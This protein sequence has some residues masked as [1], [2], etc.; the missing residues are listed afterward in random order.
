MSH[1]AHPRLISLNFFQGD[2]RLEG[3]AYPE[4]AIPLEEAPGSDGKVLVGQ[5]EIVLGAE[6][7]PQEAWLLDD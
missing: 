3:T 6:P 4:L 2:E 1:P 7:L 5:V